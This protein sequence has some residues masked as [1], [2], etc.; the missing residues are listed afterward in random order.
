MRH[1]LTALTLTATALLTTGCSTPNST[2]APAPSQAPSQAPATTPAETA[3]SSTPGESTTTEPDATESTRVKRDESPFYDKFTTIPTGV[4]KD[5]FPAYTAETK[6]WK[7]TFTSNGTTTGID[8]RVFPCDDSKFHLDIDD[9][10]RASTEAA[11]SDG[12]YLISRQLTLYP[13][14]QTAQKF[15]PKFS[16][17]GI[18]C[19]TFLDGPDTTASTTDSLIF[20][21]SYGLGDPLTQFGR[22]TVTNRKHTFGHVDIV[23]TRGNAVIWTRVGSTSMSADEFHAYTEAGSSAAAWVDKVR[24]QANL[25]LKVLS[26]LRPMSK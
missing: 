12:D 10:I 18:G 22:G 5:F 16:A 8:R 7:P 23:S 24:E 4:R 11:F 17:T 15:A 25:G 19:T 20:D 3:A 1:T 13:D 6:T 26:R 14:P 2:D 9:D 21:Q